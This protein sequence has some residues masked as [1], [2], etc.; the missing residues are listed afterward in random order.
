MVGLEYSRAAIFRVLYG[1]SERERERKRERERERERKKER[2]EKKDKRERKR[3]REFTLIG[4][5]GR[6][7]GGKDSRKIRI[8]ALARGQIV[9]IYHG[10]GEK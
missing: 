5:R 10:R 7:E 6:R 1:N 4:H 2:E 3:T 9:L 8:F